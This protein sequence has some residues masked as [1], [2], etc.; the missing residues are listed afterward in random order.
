[1]AKISAILL[2]YFSLSGCAA[3]RSAGPVTLTFTGA[4]ASKKGV[5]D[6]IS[7]FCQEG[8]YLN[9]CGAGVIPLCFATEAPVG[10]CPQLEVWGHF[11]EG[12]PPAG[13]AAAC[14]DDLLRY[15]LVERWSCI[16]GRTSGGV[17]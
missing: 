10:D 12:Y 16:D 15:F 5:Q 7:C 9:A 11:T 3:F 2:L 13:A 4:F 1:M 17:P 8:G 6:I 14:P